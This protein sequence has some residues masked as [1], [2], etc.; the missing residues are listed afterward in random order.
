MPCT[1]YREAKNLKNVA[2]VLRYWSTLGT[3]GPSNHNV[4]IDRLKL[5][6]LAEVLD[7]KPPP[8]VAGTRVKHRAWPHLVGQ[9]VFIDP[10]TD[11]A[12]IRLDSG[13]YATA[14]AYKLRRHDA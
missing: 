7:P 14:A 12:M 8:I 2:D 13:G 9:V 11:V 10:D 4:S 5:K 3:T 1:N 6:H